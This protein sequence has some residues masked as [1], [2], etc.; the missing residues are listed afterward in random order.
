MSVKEI[1]RTYRMDKALADE[2]S[3]W[4]KAKGYVAGRA[5]SGALAMFMQAPADVREHAMAGDL[6]FGLEPQD[7]EAP[8]AGEEIERA[9]REGETLRQKRRAAEG[10]ARHPRSSQG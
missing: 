9:I 3:R 5:L 1:N 10:R 6:I 7:K 4:C 8:H 2:F